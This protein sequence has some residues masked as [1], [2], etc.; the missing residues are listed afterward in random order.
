MDAC[1][2]NSSNAFMQRKKIGLLCNKQ[3]KDLVELIST[4]GASPATTIV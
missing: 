3:K 4:P 2:V 1:L